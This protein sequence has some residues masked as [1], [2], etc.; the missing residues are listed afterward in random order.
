MTK[1]RWDIPKR[2]GKQLE[3]PDHPPS[4]SSAID[5]I[6]NAAKLLLLGNSVLAGVGYLHIAGY[7]SKH[8]IQM[9]ELEI[10]LPSL[11]LNGYIYIWS[12]LSI[13]SKPVLL[14]INIVI[15]LVGAFPLYRLLARTNPKMNDYSRRMASV[16][17]VAFVLL[18]F[19]TGPA[20]VL[21]SGISL[22]NKELSD[23]APLEQVK[24]RKTHTVETESGTISG[25]LV[26]ADQ[27]YTYLRS[28]NVVYKIANDSQSV[29]RTI[30]LTSATDDEDKDEG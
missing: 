28:G 15:M 16:G 3:A 30:T 21:S 19:V 12:F 4:V 17:L 6:G 23:I 27:H 13:G 20:Y 2:K 25:F 22:A 10:N 24:T 14:A 11:L 1:K 5:L 7:L 18:A 29:V 9:S 26:R 8:G